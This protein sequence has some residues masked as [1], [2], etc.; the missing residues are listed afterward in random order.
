MRFRKQVLIS[1]GLSLFAASFSAC[2]S[3]TPGAQPHDMS[4]A[5]HD[6]MAANE[7]RN[8]QQHA[9][10]YSPD[11]AVKT[12]R[13]GRGGSAGH[14]FDGGCWT[15]TTN[16]TAAHL[17]EAKKHQKMAADHRAASQVLRDAEARACV[18]MSDDDRDES[19][20][21]HR[22]DIASVEPLT[23]S[24][25]SGKVQSARSEGAIVT[26]RA[27][28]G[29]TAQWLQRIVDCHLARNAALGHDVPEMPYCPLVPK[30]VTARVT[31]ADSG[32]A[33]AIRSDDAPTSQE[34]LRRAR[35]LVTR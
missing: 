19:P 17:D 25:T 20:F 1:A 12:D 2:A 24:V 28:P 23:V 33:V 29:M 18:G 4:A 10:H 11:A 31:A 13:C 9:S 22:E 26:F 16:P 8:S 6:T 7:D 30:N 27:L 35:A 15:S 34:V 21:M 5:H 14:D 3:T 32:F